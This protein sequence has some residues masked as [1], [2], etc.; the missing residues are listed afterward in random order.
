VPQGASVLGTLDTA[1][2]HYRR[3]SKD[4]LASKMQVAGFRVEKIL[5]F[6]RTTYPGWYVNGRLLKRRTFSRLQLSLFDRLVPLWRAIDEFL[7]WAP[8]SIIGVATRQD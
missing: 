3:Y 5:E 4:E 2:G 6:N 7:P 1:L 8:T